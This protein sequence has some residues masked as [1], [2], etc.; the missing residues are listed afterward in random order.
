[1][2]TN[3]LRRQSEG[4]STECSDWPQV[5]VTTNQL[6][7]QSEEHKKTVERLEM[8]EAEN[9]RQAEELK[10]SQRKFSDLQTKVTAALATQDFTTIQY[11]LFNFYIRKRLSIHVCVCVFFRFYINIRFIVIPVGPM[12]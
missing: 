9:K 1:M 10:D 8:L 6:R 12:V 11:F 3:Q 2:T 5:Q 7:R 4:R